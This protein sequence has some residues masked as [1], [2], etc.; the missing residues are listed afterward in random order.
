MPECHPSIDHGGD[1]PEAACHRCAA[2]DT[3]DWSAPS[4][5]WNEVMRG[6]SIN[7]GPEPFCGIICPTCFMTLAA[8]AGVASRWRLCAE[9]VHRPLETVTPSGRI[10]NEQSGLFEHPTHATVPGA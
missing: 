10:W 5:L 3:C 7:G 1:R 4:P 6:G 2:P 8:R 9:Q